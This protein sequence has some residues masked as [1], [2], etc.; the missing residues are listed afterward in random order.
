MMIYTPYVMC[1]EMYKMNSELSMILS[2]TPSYKSAYY[3]FL[4][5]H[6][7]NYGKNSTKE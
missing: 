3:E 7:N 6:K 2:E 4:E 5:M 1:W